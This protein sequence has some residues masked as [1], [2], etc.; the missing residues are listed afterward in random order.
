[1]IS[2]LII[3]G[4]IIMVGNIIAYIRFINLERRDAVR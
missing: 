3:I 2:V 4:K 1:M